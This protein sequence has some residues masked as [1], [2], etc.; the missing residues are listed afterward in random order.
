MTTVEVGAYVDQLYCL[1]RDFNLSNLPTESCIKVVKKAKMP[2]TNKVAQ[3]NLFDYEGEVTVLELWNDTAI[4]GVR[5]LWE[6]LGN[7]EEIL[8]QFK[9]L[10]APPGQ[11]KKRTTPS[12]K[13]IEPNSFMRD[14]YSFTVKARIVADIPSLGVTCELKHHCKRIHISPDMQMLCDVLPIRHFSHWHQTI[15]EQQEEDDPDDLQRLIMSATGLNVLTK[16]QCPE[17]ITK[18]DKGFVPIKLEDGDLNEEDA[19]DEQ[20][21]K[22]KVERGNNDTNDTM[23]EG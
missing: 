20:Y 19:Q 13:R 17:P 22:M 9:G 11:K 5:Y 18:P 12:L 2:G 21:K 10:D 16:R 7:E 1:K 4:L 23:E 14:M 15:E 6:L 8:L 3:I